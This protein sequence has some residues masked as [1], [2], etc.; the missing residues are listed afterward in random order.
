MVSVS[1][2]TSAPPYAA[3][4]WIIRGTGML[5]AVASAITGCFVFGAI[6]LGVC[7]TYP[8][9]FFT[10]L[11]I[12]LALSFVSWKWRSRIPFAVVFAITACYFLGMAAL[13]ASRGR[14]ELPGNLGWFA[15][16]FGALIVVGLFWAFFQCGYGMWRR[17]DKT[18][19]ANF[20][21]IFAFLVA[22][23]FY[24]SLPVHLPPSIN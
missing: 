16:L 5:I 15:T 24:Y 18:T 10:V 8:G 11:A 22:R 23:A 21:F 12:L 2:H 6:V 4:T 1:A 7:Q 3:I 19:V 20:A 14:M 13:S 17:V 9:E